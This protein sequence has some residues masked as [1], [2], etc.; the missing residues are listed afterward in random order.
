MRKGRAAWRAAEVD[1]AFGRGTVGDV[2]PV[3]VG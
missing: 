3:A 1:P 2:M